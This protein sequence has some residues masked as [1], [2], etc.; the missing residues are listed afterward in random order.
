[1]SILARHWTC[2]ERKCCRFL[3]DIDQLLYCSFTAYCAYYVYYVAI[4]GCGKC[5]CLSVAW[6]HFMCVLSAD[7]T[8]MHHVVTPAVTWSEISK[9]L[10]VRTKR[11]GGAVNYSH[12]CNKLLNHKMRHVS[13]FIQSC[14]QIL[15]KCFHTTKKCFFLEINIL[16]S[17]CYTCCKSRNNLNMRSGYVLLN[18]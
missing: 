3:V 15:N 12:M 10:G 9:Y 2:C 18:V 16:T 17:R 4:T 1:M 11:G 13:P 5:Y 14:H 6:C 7:V 8:V